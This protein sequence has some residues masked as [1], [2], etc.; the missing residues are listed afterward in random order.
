MERETTSKMAGPKVGVG[1]YIIKNHKLLLCK[2]KGSHG[3][4]QWALAGGHVEPGEN[5]LKT[6]YAEILEET[7]MI[8]PISNFKK[9]DFS[10]NFFEEENKH[11]VTMYFYVNLNNVKHPYCDQEPKLMEPEKHEEWK[12]FSLNEI[13][14]DSLFC[15]TAEILKENSW[16]LNS[17]YT[18]KVAKSNSTSKE[19]LTEILKRDENDE[20]SQYAAQN[21][22]CTPETLTEVLKRNKN[23]IVSWYAAKNPNCPPEILA[24]ILR[25]NQNDLVSES[26]ADNPNCPP[27]ILVEVLKNNS[28]EHTSV[29]AAKNQ[30]CPPE[31]L[32]EVLKRNKNNLVSQ[33]A[34]SN[35]NCPREMLVEVLKRNKNDYVSRK[36][37]KNTNCPPEILA[38][39]LRR[40]KDDLVSQNASENPNCPTISKIDW[41]INVGNEKRY[42]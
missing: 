42:K 20:V 14:F 36:A 38:E 32:V 1:I 5:Y 4:G 2:R 35:P 40:N 41:M 10:Q 3:A 23:D 28:D 11:Y 8:I 17:F 33:F 16:I 6:C 37:A 21:L 22:N 12:W 27:E 25:R 26:A 18:E 29:N 34:V 19:T 13:P 31:M 7:N 24:E 30:N 39:V 15:S 9:V